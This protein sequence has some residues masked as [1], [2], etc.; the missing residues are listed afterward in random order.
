MSF[1]NLSL[2]ILAL[3]ALTFIGCDKDDDEEMHADNEITI[4]I[5]EPGADEVITDPSDVHVHIEIEATDENHEVEII[6]HPEGDVDDAIIDFDQ[7][8]HD[9]VVIFEQ[10]VD[11]SAYP[12][13]TGFHLEVEACVDHD[14]EEKATAD[15]E[16]SIQ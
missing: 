2:F 7:H 16:F 15:V 14:C 6:L 12:S 1:K 13:G 3:G 11:L 10:E 8:T 4:N 5:L 9:K